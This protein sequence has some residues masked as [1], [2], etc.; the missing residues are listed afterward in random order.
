MSVQVSSCSI[1]LTLGH[2]FLK[3]LDLLAQSVAEVGE[4]LAHCRRS[5]SLTM[6]TAHHRDF[7]HF[8]GSQNQSLFEVSELG[9][10]DVLEGVME[11][12]GVGEVVDIF[13]GASKM[14]KL[15]DLFKF[16]C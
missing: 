16:R 11:H 3:F 5:G 7:A 6:S 12:E 2:N 9:Q 8:G 10:N 14:N 13:R 15:A 4:F 1:K